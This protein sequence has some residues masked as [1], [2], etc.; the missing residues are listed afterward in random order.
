VNSNYTKVFEGMM[1]GR[2][3]RVRVMKNVKKKSRHF[4]WK[5]EQ[6]TKGNNFGISIG[7]SKQYNKG[8]NIR[9]G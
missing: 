6:K 5:P 7:V 9:L 1:V 4:F 3:E 8:S 2:W